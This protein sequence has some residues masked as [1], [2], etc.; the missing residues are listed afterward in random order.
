MMRALRVRTD[1]AYCMSCLQCEL[2][3]LLEASRPPDADM[4]YLIEQAFINGQID[5]ETVE[6][7]YL[8]LM[9]DQHLNRGAPD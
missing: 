2:P 4:V 8:L 1:H 9:G 3:D 5:G 7:V 6:L